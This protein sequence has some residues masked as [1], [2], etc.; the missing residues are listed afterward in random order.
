MYIISHWDRSLP[1]TQ[2]KL[3]RNG[4]FR[5]VL[6]AT[7]KTLVTISGQQSNIEEEKKR[8]DNS[9]SNNKTDSDHSDNDKFSNQSYDYHCS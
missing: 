4:L 5:V 3:S 9:Y 7:W 6:K 8:I 2:N 1:I